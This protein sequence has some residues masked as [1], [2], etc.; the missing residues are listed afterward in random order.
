MSVIEDTIDL[1]LSNKSE[2]LTFW[3]S[4]CSCWREVLMS[5]SNTLMM[6]GV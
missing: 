1:D 5:L 2:F 6:S 4:C 3:N